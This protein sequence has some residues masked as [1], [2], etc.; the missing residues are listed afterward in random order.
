LIHAVTHPH[1]HR[2]DH[3]RREL[4]VRRRRLER[5]HI[6]RNATKIPA[7]PADARGL[8]RRPVNHPK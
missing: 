3:D 7:L 2:L 8:V 6:E 5:G 4:R 1:D